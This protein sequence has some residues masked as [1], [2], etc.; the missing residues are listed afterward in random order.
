M[1]LQQLFSYFD[2][3][4]ISVEELADSNEPEVS[5][6]F[7]NARQVISGSVFVAIKGF[8]SDCH[9]FLTQA[10]EN[11]A[12]ALVVENKSNIPASFTGKVLEVV[13]SRVALDQLAAIFYGFPSEQLFFFFF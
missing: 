12:A 7:F 3:K 2:A 11:G 5:G 4:S 13:D 8:K 1:K 9:E 10:V 6:I